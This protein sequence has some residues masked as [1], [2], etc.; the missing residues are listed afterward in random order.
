MIKRGKQTEIKFARFQEKIEEL[1]KKM[2]EIADPFQSN[3]TASIS[4]AHSGLNLAYYLGLIQT[5]QELS[6]FSSHLAKTHASLYVFLDE[7][8]HLRFITYYDQDCTFFTQVTCF[9][10]NNQNLDKYQKGLSSQ[11]QDKAAETMLDFWKKSLGP[12]PTLD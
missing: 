1:G 4:L 6:Q 10:E 11:R 9:D 12:P 2:K 5:I 8:Q 7:Q 3:C